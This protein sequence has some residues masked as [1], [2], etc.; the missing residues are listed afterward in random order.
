MQKP[1]KVVWKHPSELERVVLLLGDFIQLVQC[2]QCVPFPVQDH[3]K[4][5]SSIVSKRNLSYSP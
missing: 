3:K 2:L 1:F 4:S 5:N